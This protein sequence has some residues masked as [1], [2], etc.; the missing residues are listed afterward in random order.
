MSK[1]L[2]KT[3]SILLAGVNVLKQV[4]DDA[5]VRIAQAVANASSVA[6]IRNRLDKIMLDRST[7]TTNVL[8]ATQNRLA[9]LS[10]EKF[11]DEDEK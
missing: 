6:E 8:T 2:V 5:F 10:S 7:R 1:R 9:D 3:Q 11:S 4:D